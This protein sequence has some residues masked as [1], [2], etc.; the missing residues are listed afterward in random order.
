MAMTKLRSRLLGRILIAAFLAGT[1]SATHAK[2]PAGTEDAKKVEAVG[3][4]AFKRL[5]RAHGALAAERYEEALDALGEMAE[6]ERLNAHERS[7]M[8][9]T[10]GF[11]YSAEA[12]YAEAADSF[13]KSL[14]AGG[15]PEQAALQTKY[16]LA[17]LHVML[18]N[19]AA[20]IVEFQEWLPQVRNPSPNAY[21]MLA[22]A[23]FQEGDRAEAERNAERAVERSTDPREPWLQLLLALQLER[24]AYADSL[25]V[26]QRLVSRFPKKA[27]WLQLSAVHSELGDHASALAALELAYEQGMLNKGTDLISLAQLYLYN[28]IPYKAAEVVQD[29]MRNGVIEA[30]ARVYQ[31]LADSWLH[32][33][34]RDRALEPL[35]RAAEL[36]E[37]G[38]AYARL[39]QVQLERQ[40]WAEA[41]DAFRAALDKGKLHSPGHVYLLLGIANASEER[42][43]DAER[44][45]EAA[46]AFEPTEGAAR[47][48]LTHLAAQRDTDA[49]AN[50]GVTRQAAVNPGSEAQSP[51]G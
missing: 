1:A 28:Q 2:P 49:P 22:M 37:S 26:L 18:G 16:N 19:H 7:L 45:F 4:W 8:W 9:Q 23:Y 5:D 42:W 13:A 33:R 44:A 10:F 6:N 51:P 38:D 25:P 43:T 14:E 20:A 35:Q 11:V 48:W 30:D 40:R 50:E 31:L 47:Q 32:A 24:E 12:K 29:G 39:G 15:L 34:H 41:R 27:Y 46:V 17:Q 36:S 3:P 21:Y